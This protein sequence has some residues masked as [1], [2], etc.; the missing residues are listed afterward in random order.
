M[1]IFERFA[2]ENLVPVDLV[3]DLDLMDWDERPESREPE[4]AG[5]VSGF[6]KR[7]SKQT[8]RYR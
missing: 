1:D 7:Q 6:C 2:A 5:E 3:K 4:E 8:E